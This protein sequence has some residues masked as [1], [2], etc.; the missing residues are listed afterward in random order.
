MSK[1]T[2]L[3]L[4]YFNELLPNAK[5]ELNYSKD[6]ELVIAVMLS[7][8]CTDKKVNK[9]TANLF[10]KYKS[11]DELEKCS[12]ND[13]ENE[14]K[15]LGL[16]QNKVRYLKGIV[17]DLIYRFNYKVPENKI[18]LMSLPGVGNKTANV[19]RIEFFKDP[20]FPVDT[21][22][23]RVSKRLGLCS[24]NDS[25][26]VVEEKLKKTFDKDLWIKLHHQFIFFGRYHCFARNPDCE[27]CKLK[28]ICTYYKE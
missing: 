22:V 18:D 21:H 3:I 10:S 13:I 9:V 14:I 2:N 25:V 1:K 20:E 26:M 8:Q 11:L 6:Y 4:D 28:S 7:A 16:Y 27:H 24:N 23:E 5:C 12:L 19:V 15:T 17:H